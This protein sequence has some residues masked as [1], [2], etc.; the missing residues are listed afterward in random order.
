M[1]SYDKEHKILNKPSAFQ[2]DSKRDICHAE[3]DSA[4]YDKYKT[5]PKLALL[6]EINF[7]KKE[8][9]E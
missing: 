3:L 1:E 4:S 6:S 5:S 8:H 2:N 7:S 9:S